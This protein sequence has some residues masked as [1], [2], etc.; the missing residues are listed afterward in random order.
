MTTPESGDALATALRDWRPPTVETVRRV[1]PW[2]SAAFAA[3]L[4]APAPADELLRDGD[5]LSV[6]VAAQG[7]T[8]S[9]TASIRLL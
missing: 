8:P 2:Q 6:A 5:E 4:D 7:A 3:L 9:L 1:D